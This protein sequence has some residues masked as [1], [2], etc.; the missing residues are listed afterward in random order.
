MH[1][2]H[3]IKES[4]AKNGSLRTSTIPSSSSRRRETRVGESLEWITASWQIIVTEQLLTWL[5]LHCTALYCTVLHCTVPVVHEDVRGPDVGGGDAQVLDVPVLGLVPPQIVVSPLLWCEHKYFYVSQLFSRP[6]T[7][8][9]FCPNI[10]FA[11]AFWITN[12]TI[13]KALSLCLYCHH[14]STAAR[15]YSNIHNHDILLLVVKIL[16]SLFWTLKKYKLKRENYFRK[17]K[18]LSSVD[19]SEQRTGFAIILR[20]L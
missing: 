4:G 16:I 5:V 9:F 6:F 3:L 19:P 7:Q 18:Q 15:K 20:K 2:L 10:V 1:Q 8:I 17:Y 14:L 13:F 11:F 12:K